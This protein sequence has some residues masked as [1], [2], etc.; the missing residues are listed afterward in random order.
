MV[1][2]GS[3]QARRFN[4]RDLT[5]AVKGAQAAGMHIAEVVVLPTGE[6]RLRNKASEGADERPNDFDGEFG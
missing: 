3:G 1:R 5:K 4:Q 2:R 6:I